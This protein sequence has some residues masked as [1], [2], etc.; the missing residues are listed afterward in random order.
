MPEDD[1]LDF[2]IGQQVK[3]A[4]KLRRFSQEALGLD[5]GIS[6]QQIQKYEI[7]KNQIS[8]VRLLQLSNALGK[9][10]EYFYHHAKARHDNSPL[11]SLATSKIEDDEEI[12]IYKM[13]QILNEIEDDDFRDCLLRLA[14]RHT[15]IIAGSPD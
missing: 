2:L 14:K 3:Q 5:V 6:Y 15:K 12:K 13:G 4:R 11:V 1:N 8:V 9:P 10:P 7:G